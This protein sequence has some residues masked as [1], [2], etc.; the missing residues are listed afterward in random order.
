MIT[1]TTLFWAGEYYWVYR[2][3]DSA[4]HIVRASDGEMMSFALDQIEGME[5]VTE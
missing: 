4:V 1:T 2:V 3:T 5:I